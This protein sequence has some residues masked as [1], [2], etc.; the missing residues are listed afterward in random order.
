MRYKTEK[1]IYRL[2]KQL[3][4]S[5]YD[6]LK[7]GTINTDETPN[8]YIFIFG[9]SEDIN[10][11]R[12]CIGHEIVENQTEYF[13]V[14]KYKRLLTDEEIDDICGSAIAEEEAYFSIKQYF[15]R[16]G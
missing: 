7:P 3:P 6:M 12:F 5:P 10:T 8:G 11:K 15:D 16:R 9:R 13:E 4:I 1:K 2:K 14:V